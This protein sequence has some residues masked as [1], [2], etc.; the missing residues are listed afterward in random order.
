MN[1]QNKK[2][3]I[4]I[5]V[6]L[7]TTNIATYFLTVNGILSFDNSYVLSTHS[8]T[9]ATEAQKLLDLDEVIQSRYYQ[10]VDETALME[11]AIKGMFSA[12]GDKYSAYYTK[13]EFTALMES[14]TGTYEGIGVTVTEDDSKNTV[15]VSAFKDSPAGNAGMVSNDVIVKVDGE[16]VQGKGMDYVVSKMRGTAG[17]NV[18]VTV[19]RN[20]EE[21]TF[22][23]TREA[24]DED[25]VASQVLDG[26]VGYIQITQFTEKTADDF[27]SQLSDLQSKG[28]KYLI[29][30]LRDNGGGLV[31][32]SVAVADRLLGDTEVVYTVDKSGKRQDYK[33][34]ADVKLDLPMVVL[35]NGGTASASEILSGA[36]QDTAAGTLI[37]TKTFGKGI[38]QEIHPLSDGSGYKLTIAQYFT[39][40]GRN[41][42]GVGLTPDITVEQND[43][44]KDSLY[45]PQDQD[46][47]LQK[48]LET[49]KGT[50]SQTPTD[51]TSDSQ[52]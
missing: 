23:L 46:T 41:I 36:I 26:D 33:S 25:T 17:T 52:Q 32:S 13:D 18:S 4:L 10:D 44:Y 27:K 51:T 12:I 30:D 47:Q 29:I 3:V 37:G 40:K 45:V 21:K 39:P 42:H 28:I 19:S 24:I 16:D 20:G 43:A 8:A 35:V 14:S 22:E 31:D 7:V 34:T 11:N 49:L 38:V 2:T 1:S 50:S 15:V 6:L 5:V 48:A 9:G